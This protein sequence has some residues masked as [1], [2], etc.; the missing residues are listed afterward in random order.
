MNSAAWTDVNASVSK[1]DAS[2]IRFNI[3]KTPPHSLSFVSIEDANNYY[4]Q[5]GSIGIADKPSVGKGL[6]KWWRGYFRLSAI[7]A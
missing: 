7:C 1:Q 4:W 3:V 2:V 6:F 5:S